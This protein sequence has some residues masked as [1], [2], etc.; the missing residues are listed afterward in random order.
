MHACWHQRW[1]LGGGE[2]VGRVGWLTTLEDRQT[3]RRLLRRL[4]EPINREVLIPDSDCDPIQQRPELFSSLEGLSRQDRLPMRTAHCSQPVPLR[5]VVATVCC[6][7]RRPDGRHAA[8]SRRLR[9]TRRKSKNNPKTI[10]MGVQFPEGMQCVGVGGGEGV[11]RIGWLTA[12]EARRTA[13]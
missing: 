6:W 1:A 9:T 13:K 7:D 8:S 12:R 11:R 5:A 10:C 2:G 4:G 3:A